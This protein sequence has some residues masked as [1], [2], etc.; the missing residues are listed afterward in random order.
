MPNLDIYDLLILLYELYS[1][2]TLFKKP[3]NK[4]D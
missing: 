3:F 1:F 4:E 2:K